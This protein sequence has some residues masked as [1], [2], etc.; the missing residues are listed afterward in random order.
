MLDTPSPSYTRRWYSPQGLTRTQQQGR[1]TRGRSCVAPACASIVRRCRS[2]LA[3]EA[4]P[5][6]GR[7]HTPFPPCVVEQTSR[8][9]A[10]KRN[11]SPENVAPASVVSSYTLLV[12]VA[13]CDQHGWA[14][15]GGGYPASGSSPKS[16]Y[17]AFPGLRRMPRSHRLLSGILH[18]VFCRLLCCL[19]CCFCF[20]SFLLLCFISLPV[21]NDSSAGEER[22][23]HD[24]GGAARA[25]TGTPRFGP[26]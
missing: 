8:G 1:H 10:S 13:N 21:A 18:P 25:P 11:C 20:C 19:F 17:S 9:T 4:T 15:G 14:G 7:E 5:Y 24:S 16:R 2:A 23:R 12:S 22:W 6:G 26:R 3:D